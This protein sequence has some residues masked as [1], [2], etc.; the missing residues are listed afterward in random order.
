VPTTYGLKFAIYAVE[1]QRHLQRLREIKPRILVGQMTGAV[2]TQAALGRKAIQIQKHMMRD[3]G[4]KAVEVSNQVV[5]RDRHAEFLLLLALISETLNK[6]ATEIRNLQRTEINEV[7]EGFGRKQVGSSTM[8][9]KMNPIHSE[10][11]CGI[12]RVVKADAVASLGNI[13]L[14]HE[15]DL[16]NS[17]CERI[18][19]PE[20]CV[21]TDYILRLSINLVKNLVFN[22]ENIKRNLELTQGRIMAESVMIRMAEKGYN[23][24]RA[25]SIVRECALESYRKKKPFRD[26]LLGNGII[27]SYLSEKEMDLALDPSKYIGTAE[28]Q[29]KNALKKLR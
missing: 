24:Q 28:K 9:H 12:A 16:T 8:P 7:R 22:P 2:G 25:H 19:I 29:V 10:R 17:S 20:A 6:I 15:R 5:Q 1:V 14:W 3:L 4:L 11:I 27:T 18:I 13:P 21:L 23:R 26:A